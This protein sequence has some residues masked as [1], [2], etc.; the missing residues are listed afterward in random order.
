MRRLNRIGRFLSKVVFQNIAALITMGMLRVLFGPMGWFPNPEIDRI[1]ILMLS[2]FIPVLFAYTAG[3]RIGEHRGGLIA[4]IVMFGVVLGTPPH[5]PMILPSLIIGPAVGYLIRKMD[6]WLKRWVPMGFELLFHNFFAGLLAIILTLFSHFWLSALFLKVMDFIHLYIEHLTQTSYLPLIAFVIEPGKILFFNNV[7]NHGILEPLGIYQVQHLGKSILFLLETNPGPGFGM[8]LAYYFH[9]K[10][11]EKQN[12]KSALAIHGLGGIHEVYFSYALMK[13][14]V[15]IPLILGGITGNSIFY[16]L[17]AGLVATPSPGSAFVLL[18][19]A[20]KGIH[21]AVFAGIIASACISFVCTMFLLP[22]E[23]LTEIATPAMDSTENV[24]SEPKKQIKNIYFV[25]DAGMGSSAMGA[26]QLQKK[27]KQA[28]LDIKVDHYSVDDIPL[29]AD[30]VVST[31]HIADRA[32]VSAPKAEH[33]SVRSFSDRSFYQELITRLS[34]Q[35]TESS[36]PTSPVVDEWNGFT[37]EYILLN[38]QAKDKWEAIEQ[39]GALLVEM[40]NVLPP[41]IEEMKRRERSFSTYLENGVSLPHGIDAESK[42]IVK[43]GIAIAQYPD[44]VDFGDG[45][46]A[47][48]V[49]AIAVKGHRQLAILSQL[50]T[51]I[52][53]EEMMGR[54]REAQTR[55]E[56]LEMII[57]SLGADQGKGE[58]SV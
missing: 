2:Y 43:S 27:L 36:A 56:V 3:R 38:R 29:D 24:F 16:F 26:A 44:G 41:Y 39:V 33:I 1:T 4:A 8:L 53:Q 12:V 47:Y 31:V 52:E 19:M 7:I 15:I 6:E 50:A 37:K 34:S 55:E 58:T 13:P 25:C 57:S 17:Q 30:L 11:K 49:I 14:I 46:R 9:L 21:I 28:N 5:I 10:G 45:N 51:L 35:Q 42:Q 32:L 23:K 20:P 54:L 40:G 22:R 48:L 18:A